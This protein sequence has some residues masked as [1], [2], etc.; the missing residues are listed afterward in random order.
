[1]SKIDST[2]SRRE[3]IANLSKISAVSAVTYSSLPGCATTGSVAATPGSGDTIAT[4]RS[5]KVKGVMDTGIHV[6]KGI[7]YGASTGGQKTQNH[8]LR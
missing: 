7:P 6:F 5:G 4:T 8:G 3:F 2:I 1:M